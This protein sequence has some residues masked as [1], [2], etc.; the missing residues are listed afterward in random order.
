MNTRLLVTVLRWIG[1]VSIGV[2]AAFIVMGWLDLQAMTSERQ[3]QAMLA[4]G[5]GFAF[6]TVV[7]CFVD[8]R[9]GAANSVREV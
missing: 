8:R 2:P 4:L 6:A 9:V 1:W 3:S 7:G 5:F